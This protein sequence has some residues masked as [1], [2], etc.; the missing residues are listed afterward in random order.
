MK[1]AGYVVSMGDKGNAFKVLVGRPEGM[2]PLGRRRRRWEN[3]IK[4][5][6]SR[7][8]MGDQGLH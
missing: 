3:N 7:S 5:G 2:R 6:S 8:R 4:N 1:W